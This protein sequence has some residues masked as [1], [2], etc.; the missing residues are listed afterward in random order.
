V[1]A[2]L[3]WAVVS[4]AATGCTSRHPAT[5]NVRSHRVLSLVPSITDVVV[6]IGG[7]PMLTAR[8]DY[9]LDPHLT[10]LPSVGGLTNPNFEAVLRLRPDLVITW[11]DSAAPGLA[12]KLQNIGVRQ[13]PM[14]T[15]TLAELRADIRQVGVIVGR[16]H[17]ADSL[18][19]S[20]DSSLTAVASAV[21][22][23]PRRSVFFLV[24]R[25][26]FITIGRAA[27]IDTLIWIAGGE[28]VF[29]DMP[30]AWPTVSIEALSDRHVDVILV[31]T[32]AA[33]SIHDVVQD[34]QLARLVA[35]THA[36]VVPIDAD[37]VNRPGPRI[38]EAARMI[39]AVIREH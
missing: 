1:N 14:G 30:Q 2:I 19:H 31:P 25:R 33:Q 5:R 15:S 28:N 3:L 10:S 36:A 6:A 7:T 21:D 34:P 37:L 16:E 9:D 35:L 32:S 39:A 26:P 11:D 27:F 20:I 23:L 38:G 18:W 17:A 29:H 8:T 13:L 4:A 12:T 24:W 22:S